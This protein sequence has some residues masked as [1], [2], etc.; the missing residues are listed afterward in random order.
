MLLPKPLCY[1]LNLR[2]APPTVWVAG[3]PVIE[4]ELEDGPANNDNNLDALVPKGRYLH[5]VD[6]LVPRDIQRRNW[7]MDLQIMIIF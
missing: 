2:Q 6:I 3:D 5:K 1:Q 4:E 7:K